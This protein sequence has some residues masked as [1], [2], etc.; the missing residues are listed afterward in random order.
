[1]PRIKKRAIGALRAAGFYYV[2]VC[3]NCDHPGAL[4]VI[5]EWEPRATHCRCCTDCPIYVDGEYGLWSNAQTAEART[6]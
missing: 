5:D 3:A 1:M 2:V 4:H 6:L